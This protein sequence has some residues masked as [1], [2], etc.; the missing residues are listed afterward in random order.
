VVPRCADET[1]QQ[2]GHRMTHQG[3]SPLNNGTTPASTLVLEQTRSLRAGEPEETLYPTPGEQ[4]I[5]LDSG[6]VFRKITNP[7][8]PALA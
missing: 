7:I 2:L 1:G 6:F 5:L 3:P 8:E 4:L